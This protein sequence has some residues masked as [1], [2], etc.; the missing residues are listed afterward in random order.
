MKRSLHLAYDCPHSSA[1]LEVQQ[2]KREKASSVEPASVQSC[3]TVEFRTNAS[4]LH[5]FPPFFV[6]LSPFELL[7]FILTCKDAI[8]FITSHPN[9][10]DDWCIRNQAQTQMNLD[11]LI[12]IV[13]SDENWHDSIFRN[14]ISQCERL[15]FGLARLNSLKI[16]PLS[17]VKQF[18]FKIPKSV[19]P[20]WDLFLNRSSI[21]PGFV[22]PWDRQIESMIADDNVNPVFLKPFFNQSQFCTMK[23]RQILS[24]VLRSSSGIALQ[25]L[26]LYIRRS[27]TSGRR[28]QF[29]GR[30]KS[31]KSIL[32]K[33]PERF[34][35]DDFP[36]LRI[37]T[38]TIQTQLMRK[39]F[40]YFKHSDEIDH[41]W[42]QCP[43]SVFYDLVSDTCDT[44]KGKIPFEFLLEAYA[45][46]F[47]FSEYGL[48]KYFENSKFPK[49]ECEALA[50]V[51]TET[52]FF[53]RS[54]WLYNH[55]LL[56][57]ACTLRFKSVPDILI[58][59]PFEAY[60][61]ALPF[62][63]DQW[64]DPEQRG[65]FETICAYL[66]TVID[67]SPWDVIDCRRNR[68]ISF[69]WLDLMIDYELDHRV[70]LYNTDF[71]SFPKLDPKWTQRL[72][73]ETGESYKFKP[74]EFYNLCR[75]Y[76]C[77]D[78]TYSCVHGWFHYT[79]PTVPG[80]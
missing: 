49:E 57:K 68:Y 74:A 55:P 24:I 67:T 66:V 23:F 36:K 75:H 8:L 6:Y 11:A 19:E 50:D 64:S 60:K 10:M 28:A 7:D 16:L 25:K 5:Q 62:L 77:P 51:I 63:K 52:R 27:Y 14:Y 29:K 32:N 37:V 21:P 41:E 78:E 39:N 59:L 79:R 4:V 53:T 76:R 54:F 18:S 22:N 46:E 72:C 80:N 26:C 13:G 69:E 56:L 44:S 43:N 73:L 30:R 65:A 20:S 70:F 47:F 12:E 15:A 45:N 31:V 34:D 33:F 40:K 1:D 38:G 9:S 35:F 58:R 71:D 61:I 3:H 2:S 48:R 42:W 17:K